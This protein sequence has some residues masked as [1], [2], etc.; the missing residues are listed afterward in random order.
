MWEGE[1]LVEAVACAIEALFG[2]LGIARR[3]RDAGVLREALP[4]IAANAIDDWFLKGNPRAV[5]DASELHQ[6]LEL[7]W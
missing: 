4:E 7:A 5:R 3:L 2:R 6:V 1:A